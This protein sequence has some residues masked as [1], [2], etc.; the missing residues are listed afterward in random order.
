MPTTNYIGKPQSRT[1]GKKKVTG[2]AK[3]AAEFSAP[4]LLYG[5][6]V[7]SGK[8]IPLLPTLLYPPNLKFRPKR[9]ML[10]PWT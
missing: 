9:P 2:T 4:G 5:V 3:Y 1:D 7:S 10:S 8:R 6:V